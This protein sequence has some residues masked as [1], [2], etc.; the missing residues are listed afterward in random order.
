MK[1]KIE[2]DSKYIDHMHDVTE[3]CKMCNSYENSF[4]KEANERLREICKKASWLWYDM[5]FLLDFSIWKQ[6]E[7][8]HERGLIETPLPK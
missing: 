1:Y 6:I 4:S 5:R 2:L 3:I 7:E 8:Q